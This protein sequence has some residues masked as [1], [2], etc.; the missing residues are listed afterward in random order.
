MK[1]I[2]FFVGA[3]GRGGAERVVSVLSNYLCK[4]YS[5]DIVCVL[6]NINEYTLDKRISVTN[7]SKDELSISNLIKTTFDIRKYI[8][9]NQPDIIIPFLTKINVLVCIALI[10]L[11][12]NYCLIQSERIDPT[13]SHN[14]N[15]ITQFLI[16]WGLKKA[17]IIVFQTKRA[18]NFYKNILK[19]NTVIIENPIYMPFERTFPENKIIIT[20]GRLVEQKNHKLLIDSFAEVAKDY[21]EYQLHIYGEGP[22]RGKLQKQID[23][24]DLSGQ[25]FLKGNK[26][27]YLESLAKSQIF[28]LSSNFEGLSNAL[29]EAMVLGLP[30]ISTNCSGSDEIIVNEKN[31]LLVPIG[32]KESMKEAIRKLLKDESLRNFIGNNAHMSSKKYRVE[33]IIKK[34]E[35][36]LDSS[37]NI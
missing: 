9:K 30:C 25:V 34:W 35:D 16:N 19:A 3:M 14:R 11:T 24:L 26:L 15:R 18:L 36:I 12:K 7:L 28:V 31:G 8:K 6:H 5:I 32:D 21:P 20:A 27:D 10:G 29:L 17:D 33:N 22:L 2:T 23:D 13:I 1:K 37:Q 4:K